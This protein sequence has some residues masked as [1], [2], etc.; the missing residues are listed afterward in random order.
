[1]SVIAKKLLVLLQFLKSWSFD[2]ETLI[3]NLIQVEYELCNITRPLNA[4]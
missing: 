1:M 2:E 4:L 3:M